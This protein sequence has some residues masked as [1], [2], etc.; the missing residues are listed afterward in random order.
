MVSYGGEAAASYFIIYYGIYGG[1]AA[2]SYFI[3]VSI[4]AKPPQRIV[5]YYLLWY[6]WRRSR[7]IVFIM[8]SIAADRILLWYLWRRSRRI[9]RI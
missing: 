5:F 9:D 4:A 1:E 7:R 8:V 3:M 2:A 6:L